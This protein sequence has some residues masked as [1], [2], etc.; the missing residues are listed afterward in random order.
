MLRINKVVIISFL[1]FTQ[2]LSWAQNNTN[3]PYTRFGYG[4][5]ADR[6]FGAGR[7]MGGVGIGLRSSKQI[8]PMNPASYSCMDTLTFLFDFGASGQVS[9]FYDGT[10]KQRQLNGNVEYIALQFPITRRL[11]VSVGLLPFSHVGYEFGETR[12][13]NGLS[14]GE[15]FS[16]SGSLSDLYF[17]DFKD[18]FCA[19]VVDYLGQEQVMVNSGVLLINLQKW[20]EENAE[21]LIFNYIEHNKEKIS[22]GDQEII[23]AVFKDKILLL[24]D[25]WNVQTLNFYSFS[26]YEMN[27]GIVHFIG[28]SK[29]WLFGSFM[30]FK[31]KFFYYMSK[32]EWGCP[33]LFWQFVSNVYSYLRYL[34]RVPFFWL[35]PRFFKALKN[36]IAR[37]LGFKLKTNL[38]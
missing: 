29:P 6:S 12:T 17:T 7:A 4:E 28:G 15:S 1:I 36:G 14:W 32:T 19:G 21:K 18:N 5:L 38:I 37:G 30:P 10:N 22:S 26:N 9:W 27:Y 35:R 24:P 20:R 2:W 31:K 23:N 11:A 3:S 13:E 34:K 33:S 8:N 16:G 25:M